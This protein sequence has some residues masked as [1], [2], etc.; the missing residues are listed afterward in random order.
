MK[1]MSI[2]I[3][4]VSRH[5]HACRFHQPFCF[6]S[7]FNCFITEKAFSQNTNMGSTSSMESLLSGGNCLVAGLVTL[8]FFQNCFPRS[9]VAFPVCF[10]VFGA[11]IQVGNICFT[12]IN[13]IL[14]CQFTVV[15]FDLISNIF[16]CG[17]AS[18]TLRM[19]LLTWCRVISLAGFF[20]SGWAG[21]VCKFVKIFQACIQTFLRVT[22]FFF[23]D[24][25]LLC[26]L[27]WLLWAK[28]LEFF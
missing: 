8:Q 14:F 1:S 18:R 27:R 3:S 23:R 16:L 26:S 2:L 4:V 13:L 15:H 17:Y 22:T 24:I 25:D 20:G 10:F 5:K 28:C 9:S 6:V 12:D 19:K 7:L 11:V 21:L